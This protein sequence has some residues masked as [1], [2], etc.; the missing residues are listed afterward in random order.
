MRFVDVATIVQARR[1]T[2][3]TPTHNHPTGHQKTWT[4]T[5]LSLEDTEN[6]LYC[7]G[8][9]YKTL[10]TRAQ[11][12]GN[13][14]LLLEQLSV[15]GVVATLAHMAL[16]PCLW[17]EDVASSL[18]YIRRCIHYTGQPHHFIHMFYGGHTVQGYGE[19]A[20]LV[21]DAMDAELVSHV[22]DS[23]FLIRLLGYYLHRRCF[24]VGAWEGVSG[25]RQ[26]SA[27]DLHQAVCVAMVMDGTALPRG[28]YEHEL[29]LFMSGNEARIWG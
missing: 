24:C 21:P 17:V 25:L 13:T 9:H 11:Q 28:P 2:R 15:C 26:V 10:A 5:G 19:V 29:C 14:I 27:E 12:R 3:Y 23:T 4:P 18:G 22:G 7:H 1:F 20:A 6:A 8:N 16:L